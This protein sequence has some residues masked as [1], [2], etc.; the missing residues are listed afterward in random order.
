MNMPHK[1]TGQS[2]IHET[3]LCTFI[4][5]MRF[6]CAINPVFPCV[7]YHSYVFCKR[8]PSRCFVFVLSRLRFVVCVIVCV[9]HRVCCMLCSCYC[10]VCCIPYCL[11]PVLSYVLFVVAVVV[12]FT[13][14]VFC[15]YVLAPTSCCMLIHLLELLCV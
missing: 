10:L 3:M 2:N 9:S 11:L 13:P 1:S 14:A 7:L 12:C 5:P 8:Y 4:P 6:A 15:L